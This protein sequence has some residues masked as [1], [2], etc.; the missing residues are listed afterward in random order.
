M[1][2]KRFSCKMNQLHQLTNDAKGFFGVHY[3]VSCS[4]FIE[5]RC[6]AEN[7]VQHFYSN[8]FVVVSDVFFSQRP[9]KSRIPSVPSLT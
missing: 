4:R 3:F 5:L 7:L 8:V 6:C 1:K 9:N 2:E